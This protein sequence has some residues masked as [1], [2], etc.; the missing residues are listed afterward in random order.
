MDRVRFGNRGRR[1]V[2]EGGGVRVK[3]MSLGKS[4]GL[5]PVMLSPPGWSGAAQPE[6][7]QVEPG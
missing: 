3:G 6:P 1:E 7:P 5:W 4:E 2:G